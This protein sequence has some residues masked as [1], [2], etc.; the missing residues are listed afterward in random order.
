MKSYFKKGISILCI[1]IILMTCAINSFA[2]TQPL[3]T[4]DTEFAEELEIQD[5]VQ[6]LENEESPLDEEQPNPNDVSVEDKQNVMDVVDIFEN[7]DTNNETD[8]PENVMLFSSA[9]S[10]FSSSSQADNL[11]EVAKGEVGTKDDGNNR[12]KYNNYTTAQWC[13]YFV[14]WC[15]KQAGL[16]NII[17][18]F[19]SCS[20]G[21]NT[22]LPN[23]GGVK[24][25]SQTRGGSY[26]PQKGDIIFFYKVS[27]KDYYG[28][29]HVGIA[30]KADNKKVYY[31]DGNHVSNS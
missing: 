11:V 3:S 4:D 12:V 19:T 16:S 14:S 31:I 29:H 21:Y 9:I 25:K 20:T 17:P 24:H 1:P 22:T 27:T 13:G 30:Y 18:K 26:S 15:S 8:E 7:S 28:I 5:I 23:A 6:E 2:L 10:L